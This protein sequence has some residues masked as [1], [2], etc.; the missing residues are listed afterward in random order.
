M[1]NNRSTTALARIFFAS[2]LMP[3]KSPRPRASRTRG[4]L[5]PSKLRQ[6]VRAERSGP[7]HQPFLYEGIERS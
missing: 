4:F 3:A 5:I 7:L 6:Q 1:R 2:S